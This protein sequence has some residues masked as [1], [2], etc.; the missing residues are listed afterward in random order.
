MS[1][2]LKPSECSLFPTLEPMAWCGYLSSLSV[3]LKRHNSQLRGARSLLCITFPFLLLLGCR[4]SSTQHDR[5]WKSTAQSHED[6][7]PWDHISVTL[8]SE[9][10]SPFLLSSNFTHFFMEAQGLGFS[11]VYLPLKL[12][13]IWS[14]I[15]VCIFS[16]GLP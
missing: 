2:L 6:L 7:F 10:L 1:L 15:H 12:S 13:K 5:V 4:K 16:R 9:P 11:T 14:K 8:A 3:P